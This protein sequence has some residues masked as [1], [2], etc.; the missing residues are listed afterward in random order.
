MAAKGGS[1]LRMAAEDGCPL[2]SAEENPLKAPEDGCSLKA[3]E[4]LRMAA[5]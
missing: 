4:P 5:S 3:A 1:Q 2:K